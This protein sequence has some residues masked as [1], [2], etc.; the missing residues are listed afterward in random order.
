MRKL[1]K[2]TII[3]FSII[4]F[5]NS[6]SQCDLKRVTVTAELETPSPTGS[7]V[8]VFEDEFEDSELD[9]EKWVPEYGYGGGSDDDDAPQCYMPGNI[10]LNN[11][12]LTMIWREEPEEFPCTTSDPNKFYDKTHTGAMIWSNPNFLF[13]KFEAKILIPS[14]NRLFPAFW[15][16][17]QSNGEIDIYES[18]SPDY[19]FFSVH[20]VENGTWESC[21]KY[22]DDGIDYSQDYHIYWAIWD[23]FHIEFYIDNTL[24]HKVWKYKTL[25]YGKVDGDDYEVGKSYR[26]LPAFPRSDDDQS[27]ILNLAGADKPDTYP[28]YDELKV[29][30]IRA[31]E[32]CIDFPRRDISI[33]V[34]D[35][36]TVKGK[37]ITI[38]GGTN[39]FNVGDDIILEAREEIVINNGFYVP[40]GATLELTI[41]PLLYY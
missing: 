39:N 4:L 6:Y 23:P 16:W 36:L 38:G 14:G 33:S 18:R 37:T 40:I 10:I 1:Q 17:T 19:P 22:P 28:A 8:K 24:V 41:N 2:L 13:G 21:I 34:L 29:D 32:R 9:L 26:K 11:G 3:L 31:Y 15:L 35:D 5:G 27:L 20:N 7:W 25:I 12:E 30:W